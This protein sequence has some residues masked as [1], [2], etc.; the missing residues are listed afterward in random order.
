MLRLLTLVLAL[1][2]VFGHAQESVALGE[3]VELTAEIVAIDRDA[4]LITLEDE[5]GGI[6]E[7]LAGPELKRFDELEVGDTLTFHFYESIVS[8][9]RRPGEPAP[10]PSGGPTL[11]RG[12]GPRPSGTVSQQFRATVT[13]KEID[14][15]VPSVTVETEDGRTTSFKIADK[16]HLEGVK[17]G[18]RVDITY[19]AA[20][21]IA[22][23]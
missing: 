9:V 15:S 18:D 20:V 7:V 5:A 11:V 1:A 14:A 17:P 22:V 12:T 3:S 19:T 16:G 6:E 10:P 21:I 4:R 2:P 23:K 13:V 8:Q